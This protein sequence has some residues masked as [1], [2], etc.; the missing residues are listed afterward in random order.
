MRELLRVFVVLSSYGRD[1]SVCFLQMRAYIRLCL[2]ED[3]EVITV[4]ADTRH[5]TCTYWCVYLQHVRKRKSHTYVNYGRE[6]GPNPRIKPQIQ[7][8]RF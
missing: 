1:F 6:G 4:A 7:Q 8:K 2:D 5:N 3:L